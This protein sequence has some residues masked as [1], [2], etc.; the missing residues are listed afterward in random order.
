MVYI[1]RNCICVK[2][3]LIWYGYVGVFLIGVIIYVFIVIECIFIG[4]V[5]FKDVSWVLS[6]FVNKEIVV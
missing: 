5:L 1:F 6:I 2:G 4:G 3:E